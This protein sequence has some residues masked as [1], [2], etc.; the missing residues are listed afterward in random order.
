MNAADLRNLALGLPEAEEK[1]HFGKADFRVKDRIFATLPSE[2]TAVVKLTPE[3]QQMVVA[4]E[5]AVFAPV[6]GGCGRKGWTQVRLSQADQ[7]TLESALQMAWRNAAPA[8]LKTRL[9]R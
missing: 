8:G 6:K 5:P 1:F 2:E 4:S 7:A 3:E 9:E